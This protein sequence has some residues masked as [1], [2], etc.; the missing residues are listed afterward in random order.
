MTERERLMK[1]IS[2]YDFAVIELQIYLDTHP[3]DAPLAAKLK[4][5]LAKSDAL[6]KEYEEKFGP[7]QA[8]RENSNRWAWISNPWPWDSNEEGR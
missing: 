4:E 7:I 6:R 3:N 1:R 8:K 2:S 5:Y